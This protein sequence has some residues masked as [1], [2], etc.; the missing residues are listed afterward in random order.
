MNDFLNYALQSSI[1]FCVFFLFYY[2]VLRSEKTFQFNRFYLLFTALLSGILPVLEFGFSKKNIVTS[3]INN[4]AL[5]EI[6][7]INATTAQ[8]TL[9]WHQIIGIIYFMGF[10]FLLSRLIFQLNKIKQIILR[11]RHTTTYHKGA[12]IINTKG[13]LPTFSF[14]NHL[15][16]DDSLVF[17]EQEKEQILNHELVHIHQ[18]HSWDVL[19]FEVLGVVFWFNPIIKFYKR[20]VSTNH[21][22]IADAVVS[23][24]SQNQSYPSLIV[25][26]LFNYVDLSIGSYFNQSQTLLRIKML[27]Q[28]AKKTPTLKL[29][30]SVPLTM[31]LMLIMSFKAGLEF[32][33]IPITDSMLPETISNTLP[34]KE[35]IF[36]I[37]EEQPLPTGGMGAFYKYVG[38]NLHYPDE[39]KK[40]GI[41]GKVFAKFMVDKN[42]K[43]SHVTILKGIGYGCDKEAI[44]VLEN[45]PK[46]I[47]GK[48]GGKTVNVWMT[49]PII[50]KLGSSE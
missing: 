4:I 26:Q 25:R 23:R 16:W 5:K 24:N 36:T 47:V 27:K 29:V 37:V 9:E 22:F 1:C 15:F 13:T 8:G 31:M 10:F 45:S 33:N 38:K 40:S 14:M 49:I 41:E 48:N 18:K 30:M 12:L 35:E 46:W 43:L 50:F 2:T 19:F 34:D 3:A 17:N 42:G 21:E 11:N 44:K 7:I 39:A 32:K 20:A 28:A 6:T